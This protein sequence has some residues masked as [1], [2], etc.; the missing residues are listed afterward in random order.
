MAD[1]TQERELAENLINEFGKNIYLRR[2]GVNGVA[3]EDH[4]QLNTFSG[5]FNGGISLFNLSQISSYNVKAFFQE[6]K[7][8]LYETLNLS[9][10]DKQCL[11]SAKALAESNFTEAI[12]PEKFVVD[13]GG[14]YWRVLSVSEVRPADDPIYYTLNLT[15]Q[16][17]NG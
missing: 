16:R 11:I 17:A 2:L 5:Y 15:R 10:G 13:D 9:A 7:A 12:S 8:E 1:Y 4:L 3:S 14:T 6:I